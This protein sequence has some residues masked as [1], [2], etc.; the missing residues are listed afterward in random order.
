MSF[1]EYEEKIRQLSHVESVHYLKSDNEMAARD[2]FLNNSRL[3][4]PHFTYAK[5]DEF[6]L[7]TEQDEVRTLLANLK[8]DSDLTEAQR[9]SLMIDLGRIWFMIELIL[10][11]RGYNRSSSHERME[12]QAAR[13]KR[14]NEALYG[15]FHADTFWSL[16]RRR[17]AQIDITKLS[18]EDKRL[19]EEMLS[20]IGVM[21]RNRKRSY[22][23]KPQTVRKF[24]EQLRDLYDVILK[25]I[26]ADRD[27]FTGKDAAEITN[28]IIENEVGIWQ[29]ADKS[30]TR[31][32]AVFDKKLTIATVSVHDRE[33]RYPNKHYTRQ[34]LEKI[35]IHE[36]GVHVM[37]ALSEE[38]QDFNAFLGNST[39]SRLTEEG[40]AKVCEQALDGK[41]DDICV[42]RYIAIGLIA[43]CG[44]NFRE[45]YEILWR[46][47]KLLGA[48]SKED[49]FDMV[50]RATRGTAVLPIN[51]DLSYYRG[52]NLVWKYI[53]EHINDVG[54]MQVLF[55]SGKTDFLNQDRKTQLKAMRDEKLI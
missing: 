17:V 2:E 44:K 14:A 5:I 54:L 12:M 55:M 47:E 34:G 13:L 40:L 31:F 24:G 7:K 48:H 4:R 35:I 49:C 1:R 25:Y 38:H 46:L 22:E 15:H 9:E 3:V 8:N 26:P 30:G 10:A 28:R 51:T 45:A 18:A 36:F 37:R 21:G 16:L 52:Q 11:A 32:R 53:E 19:H 41:Y 42:S 20:R 27:E 6:G 23:P 29:N 33:I 43:V 39:Y 50:S